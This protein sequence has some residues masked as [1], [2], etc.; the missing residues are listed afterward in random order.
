[1]NL[2]ARLSD[3]TSRGGEA[4]RETGCLAR[5]LACPIQRTTPA[6]HHQ[7]RTKAATLKQTPATT[8]R[9]INAALRDAADAS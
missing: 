8:P 1:M 3:A 5:S 6:R 4:I 9:T 7:M 2:L